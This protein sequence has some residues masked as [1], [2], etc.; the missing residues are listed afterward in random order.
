[1]IRTGILETLV[2]KHYKEILAD[3]EKIKGMY[4]W[5]NL[6]FLLLI[7]FSSNSFAQTK[8]DTI[9]SYKSTVPVVIDGSAADVCW[10]KANWHPID[11]V[12]IPYGAK[13]DK[14]D[15]E[16]KFKVSWDS[17][18]L[19]VLVE[20]V[21]DM[22]SDDHPIPTQ[23]WWDDDC[24]EIFIDEDRSGGNHERNNNAFAYHIS[25]TYDAID[26]D[27]SGNGVNYK[28]NIKVVMDTI[29]L[30]TYLWEIAVK[31]YN[32]GFTINN[33][34]ASRVKLTNK[35]L[36]GFTIAYC[37]NDKGMT[38]E[39]FIGS[40]YMT[41]K[42]ANDNYITAD[43]F[44][45]LLLVDPQQVTI[46]NPVANYPKKI[47][48]VFPNPA[49]NQIKLERVDNSTGQLLIEIRSI[50]GVLL[51]AQPF[52]SQSQIIKTDDLIPGV[53]LLSVSSENSYQSERIVIQ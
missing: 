1:V 18:Y 16:G 13:M 23:N 19:Y 11:Q 40:M 25:L 39:N 15:F 28:N 34:E 47:F 21:D 36:M 52:E 6:L 50:T 4:I 51:K 41:E 8:T 7:L 10:G 43:Y 3:K 49:K 27:A 35:K 31:I 48:S 44:G 26:L 22:L 9:F 20:V 24:L 17:L 2:M 33:P 38:R 29:G 53:Y 5:C 46:I 12:W 32:A 42:T 14:N 37:D 45:S 30:N